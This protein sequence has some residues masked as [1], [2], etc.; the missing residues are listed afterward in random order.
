MKRGAFALVL[1]ALGALT[2]PSWAVQ[3]ACYFILAATALSLVYS[4]VTRRAIVLAREMGELKAHARATVDVGVSLRNRS[5]LPLPYVTL[6]DHAGTL[7]P[8]GPIEAVL[9]VEPRGSVRFSYTLKTA[10]RGEHAVGPV[11]VGSSDPLE[12]FAW[13]R[14]VECRARVTVFPPLGF[15]RVGIDSG[16]AGGGIR[17]TR[18]ELEDPSRLRGVREYVAGDD[19]RRIHWKATARLG[20]LHTME[21][22]STL[23]TSCLVVLDL[24]LGR[25]PFRHRFHYVERAVETAATLLYAAAS[26]RQATALF[27]AARTDSA[28]AEGGVAVPFGRGL[29]HAA[30]LLTILAG[31]LPVESAPDPLM[32]ALRAGLRPAPD[33]RLCVVG[34]PPD[35]ATLELAE[36]CRAAR[37]EVYRVGGSRSAAAPAPGRARVYDVS[38][39]GEELAGE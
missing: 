29:E 16:S 25:Y 15:V 20:R 22:D 17:S 33:G 26:T 38:S 19:P 11:E 1:A 10:E 35:A 9:P 37:V 30:R 18:T 24:G 34:P 8:L 4:L 7:R 13:R 32:S 27:V 6:R 31:V 28:G 39:Y 2:A 36:G 23:S 14:V 3:C 21:F 5:L 12:L